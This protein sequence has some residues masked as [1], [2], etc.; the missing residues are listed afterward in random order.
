VVLLRLSLI[1][2][3]E[4]TAAGERISTTVHPTHQAMN[5]RSFVCTATAALP[6]LLFAETSASAPGS[7]V[8]PNIPFKVENGKDRTDSPLSLF[9]GDTFFTK[10]S[11][12][13]TNGALYIFEST[14]VKSGG[15][16]QHVHFEQDEW[17]Y[18]LSGE[19]VIKVGDTAHEARAG[20]SVFGPRKIPHV[21]AKVSEGPAKMLIGFQPAGGMEEF[22]R[23]VSEGK[24][25]PLS[26]DAKAAFRRSHGFEVVGPALNHYKH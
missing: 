11:G 18:V 1:A 20:D 13:D 4:A 5:R 26:P 2:I 3:T 9:E 22:F 10:V 23:A 15:P 19:F 7:S 17:W 14:R 21:W 24:V 8:H 12:R 16:A 6:G 25:E